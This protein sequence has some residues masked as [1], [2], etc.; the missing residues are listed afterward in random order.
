ATKTR[1]HERESGCLFRAL[2]CSW[3]HFGRHSIG[4]PLS[5]CEGAA[6]V[7]AGDQRRPSYRDGVDEIGE[8]APQRLLVGHFDVAA[9]NRRQCAVVPYHNPELHL[10]LR[11]V[12]LHICIGLEAPYIQYLLDAALVG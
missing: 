1:K 3:L 11:L 8:L 6:A 4:N 7:L 12:A 10:L 9:L 5:E 2:V